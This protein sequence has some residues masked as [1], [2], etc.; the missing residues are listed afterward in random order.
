MKKILCA[1]LSLVLLLSIA[2]TPAFAE[3]EK[4]I[5]VGLSLNLQDEI[6]VKFQEVYRELIE[7][8][9]PQIELIVTNA[10]GDTARQL[11]DVES[12]LEQDVDIIILRA[13]DADA[14]VACVEK[15]KSTNP[16]IYIL[17]HDSNVNSDLWDVRV[18]GDQ[19]D[20]G[21]AIGQYLKEYLDADESR[22]VNMG[23]IHGGTTTTVMRRE[24]GIYDICQE[25]VDAGRLNTLITGL[26]TWSADK[27]MALAEDWLNTYPEIN[28][29]AAASDEMAIGVIQALEGA[30]VDMDKFLVF[31][32]DGTEAGQSYIRSGE[33]DATSYQNIP[34]AVDKILEVCVGLMNGQTYEKEINPNNYFPMTKD[35][36]DELVGAAE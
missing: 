10:L 15:I 26:A 6:N 14:G 3:E 36:I 2:A 22:V 8:K 24:T 27:A 33:L 34:V 1:L 9:Y 18:M 5:V 7:T 19:G 23:Y 25:Y 16:D 29:I 20:H 31:G 32:V 21:H 17:L 11:S 13:V 12:L 35:T 28:C 4:K 30:G